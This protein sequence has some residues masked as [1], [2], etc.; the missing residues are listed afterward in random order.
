CIFIKIENKIKV[1]TNELKSC[2]LTLI[3]R[4]LPMKVLN[5]SYLITPAIFLRMKINKLSIFLSFLVLFSASLAAQS[6]DQAK[7]DAIRKMDALLTVIN[8]AYVDEIDD[9]KMMEDAI[10]GMLKELDHHSVYIPKDELKKMNEPLEGNF[11]GVGI[12]FNIFK[13]TLL[14]VSPISGGPS[15]KLGI[16]S[17]DKIIKIDGE[18]VAGV[19]L[20]NSDVQKKLRGEKGTIVNVEIKRGERDELISFDIKRDEIPIYSIDASYMANPQTAYIKINRFARNTV[21]EFHLAIDSLKRQGAE[22]LILDL[23]G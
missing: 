2:S 11:E 23:R 17:G 6:S 3:N 22:N 4:A 8:Y 7:V 15:E 5:L 12:Q 13:D 16:L 10:V 19:G 20:K 9:E 14:V 21:D 18:N 1:G